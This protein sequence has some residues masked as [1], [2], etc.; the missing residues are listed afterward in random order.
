MKTLLRPWVRS[1][2]FALPRRGKIRTSCLN[3]TNIAG[4]TLAAR[5]ASRL[6]YHFER[7]AP[8]E[9][10]NPLAG[11]SKQCRNPIALAQEWQ[12]M[13]AA[14]ERA[15]RAD[16]AR[17]LGVS[18]ARIPQVLGLLDLA[19]TCRQRSPPSATRCRGR[20]SASACSVSCSRCLRESSS[21]RWR[22]CVLRRILPRRRRPLSHPPPSASVAV[23][24]AKSVDSAGPARSL[25]IH[26]HITSGL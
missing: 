18:R 15:S 26:E 10:F 8:P 11:S 3:L 7:A 5:G 12:Q 2:R 22:A 17:R 16:L 20:F 21:E 9:C 13:L 25:Q 6:A 23:L 19:R 4:A 1:V 14:G 24:G